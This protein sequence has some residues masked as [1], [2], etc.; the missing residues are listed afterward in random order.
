[1]KTFLY[2]R[3]IAQGAKMVSFANWEM[4]I[5]YRGVLEEHRCVR[6]AVGLFDVSHMGIIKV[7]GI[8]AENLLNFV[9]TNQIAKK[10]PGT[11]TYTVFA[12]EDGGSVD[13]V[14]IYT[15][16]QTHFFIVVNASNREKDL[17][18][19]A[20]Q[21]EREKCD[22]VIEESYKGTGILALQGP[23]AIPLLSSLIP[24]VSTLKPMQFTRVEKEEDIIVS[25]T[26]YTGSGGFEIYGKDEHILQ[27]WDLLLERGKSFGIQPIGLG[28][29]DTLRLEMGFALYGHELTD[30][31]APIESVS[32]W[33]VHWEKKRFLGKEKLVELENSDKKR[34]AYGI[35]LLD[36]GIA[37]QGCP[38]FKDNRAIGFV[39]SGSYSPSLNQA[40]ALILVDSPLKIGDLLTVQIRQ[41]LCQC[42]VTEL[43]FMRKTA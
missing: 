15:I 5:F 29:R 11:A 42:Q 38:I 33:T 1:M 23:M 18:H 13:D 16:D 9:S 37:R 34:Y 24:E 8:D 41:T 17:S 19:L 39:T 30:E 27:W 3:H 28:A 14:M 10:K 4:P 20:T 12:R 26:G 36:K 6:E 40:I 2:D 43:P 35:R 22:V 7:T 25:R 31:I 32:G 21:S